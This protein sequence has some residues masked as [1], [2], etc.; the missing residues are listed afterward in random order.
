MYK[1]SYMTVSLY[2]A[3][4][5]LLEMIFPHLEKIGIPDAILAGGTALARYYLK[6][7]VSYDLDFFVGRAFNPEKLAIELGKIGVR[8]E[9]VD[10]QYEGKWARQLHAN[11]K[12][13]DEI[14]K[15]SFIEDL[16]VDMWPHKQ[17][18][19]VVTEE[20]GGLYHRKLRTI[21]GTGYGKEV[22]GTRQTAR[23]LFDVYV[24]N[25]QVQSVEQFL[26]QANEQGAN[27]PIDAWCAN[28]L[29]MPWID[30]MSEFENLV[31]LPP[32]E[33]VSLI[34]DVKPAL[35]GQ[36][37]ALQNIEGANEKD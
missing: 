14:I 12:I 9:D 27:F 34:G 18:G 28:I 32:Y 2:K 29:A 23:D 30:L 36:A 17:F 11:A 22:Q 37:L 8:L 5:E 3:Q 10:A 13:G 21:S 26:A 24:L 6:H 19:Q 25:Q 4:D 7:R 35:V 33:K 15:V 20:I 31:F 16:Y 1:L